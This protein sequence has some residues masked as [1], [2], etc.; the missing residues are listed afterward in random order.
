V[1]RIGGRTLLKGLLAVALLAG[2]GQEDELPA[3]CRS[4]EQAVTAALASAPG[5]VRLDDRGGTGGTAISG[6]MT[7]AA[8]ASDLQGLGLAVNGTAAKLADVAADRPDSP[9]AVRL[10]YLVGA[11]HR[12]SK[13]SQGLH[14]ELV[15][16]LDLEAGRVDQASPAFRR[17]ERA[18]LRLG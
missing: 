2:C 15:R 8:D 12:G 11:V 13:H 16:R 5:P 9:Q 18:G 10:G 1:Q 4:G 3:A 14:S 17:G 7:D 6:C